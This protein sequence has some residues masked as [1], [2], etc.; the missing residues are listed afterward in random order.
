MVSDGHF[1]AAGYCAQCDRPTDGSDILCA[2]CSFIE[3]DHQSI[4]TYTMRDW[5][6]TG[7]APGTI[8]EDCGH[9]FTDKELEDMDTRDFEQMVL[10][11]ADRR[12]EEYP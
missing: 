4:V 3:C 7:I 1:D 5:R 2:D 6:E 12:R 10:D 11:K 8:C 9:E